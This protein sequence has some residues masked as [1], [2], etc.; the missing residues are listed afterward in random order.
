MPALPPQP[1]VGLPLLVPQPTSTAAGDVALLQQEV[2]L[3][4]LQ[5]AQLQAHVQALHLLPHVA[6]L[7]LLPGYPALSLQQQCQ[8]PEPQLEQPRPQPAAPAADVQPSD[9]AQAAPAEQ[10]AAASCADATPA[11]CGASAQE[12]KPGSLVEPDSPE[13]QQHAW[14]DAEAAIDEL[15]A[16]AERAASVAGLYPVQQPAGPE[17]QA[18]SQAAEQPAV[19][20]DHPP[21]AA[22]GEAEA[23]GTVPLGGCQ[24][25]S[26][27]S[28]AA[29][30]ATMDVVALPVAQCSYSISSEEEED[31]EDERDRELCRKYGL[32]VGGGWAAS[33]RHRSRAGRRWDLLGVE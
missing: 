24:P 17:E 19:A 14:R 8:P 18:C 32:L 28:P 25:G 31:E 33:P 2:Q 3:L 27:P 10:P 16:Q 26:A 12:E 1:A 6:A 4:R 15:I 13:E 9:A 23:D 29:A 7:S 5:V 20:V 30:A 22:G 21:A 11:Q